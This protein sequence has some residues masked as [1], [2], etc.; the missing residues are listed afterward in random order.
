MVPNRL[1]TEVIGKAFGESRI[2]DNERLNI[3]YEDGP[4]LSK[5]SYILNKSKQ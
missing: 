5:N 3:I 2:L 1:E 4:E